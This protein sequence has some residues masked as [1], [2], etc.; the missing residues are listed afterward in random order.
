M[1]A[2]RRNKRSNL[3][4]LTQTLKEVIKDDAKKVEPPR[5]NET[6]PETAQPRPKPSKRE[7][8]IEG[9]GIIEKQMGKKPP[10]FISFKNLLTG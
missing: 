3:A 4:T 9:N 1:F 7:V 8:S 2:K 6:T 5:L 10:K